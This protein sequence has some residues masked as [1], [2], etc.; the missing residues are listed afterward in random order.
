[1]RAIVPVAARVFEA[2][3]LSLTQQNMSILPVIDN[4]KAHG[5][6]HKWISGAEVNLPTFRHVV[7]RPCA[8]REATHMQ[9]HVRSALRVGLDEIDGNAHLDIALPDPVSE[10]PGVERGPFL[11]ALGIVSRN[12]HAGETA[13]EKKTDMKRIHDIRVVYCNAVAEVGAELPRQVGARF[14][15]REV[16]ANV[17]VRVVPEA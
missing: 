12:S 17:Q 3:W 9:R 7:G 4:E 14:A 11:R 6:L 13:A 16:E 5:T 10:Q 15:V 1:M 2:L 8:R